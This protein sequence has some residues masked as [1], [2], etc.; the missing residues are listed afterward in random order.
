MKI[1]FL[2]E[3]DVLEEV[4][5]SGSGAVTYKIIR[6][7]EKFFVKVMIKGSAENQSPE[8]LREIDRIYKSLEIPCVNLVDTGT[9]A[10]CGSTWAVWK[11]IDSV[12]LETVECGESPESFY[13]VGIWTG[14]QL[15]K[16]AD[17]EFPT[18]HIPTDTRFDQYKSFKDDKKVLIHYD[19]KPGNILRDKDGNL[20]LCDTNS[21]RYG[22]EM[23]NLYWAIGVFQDFRGEAYRH[24]FRGIFKTF[25]GGKYNIEQMNTMYKHEFTKRMAKNKEEFERYKPAYDR[26]VLETNNFTT[27][28]CFRD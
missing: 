26:G 21:T 17:Y 25:W 9:L 13:D 7:N 16:L 12:N 11:W 4:P 1:P 28:I 24:F 23:V 18:S 3:G 6:G 8:T 14:E 20:F 27:G 5:V 10:G 19:I 15:R 22:F 2:C